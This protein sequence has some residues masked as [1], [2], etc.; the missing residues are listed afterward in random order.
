MI[1]DVKS[2]QWVRAAF[3]RTAA[4]RPV[5]VRR[6]PT[7]H[8]AEA[9]RDGQHGT[10]GALRRQ[11]NLC[12]KSRAPAIIPENLPVALLTPLAWVAGMS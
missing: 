2:Q 3:L 10:A 6:L 11:E 1:R 9:G 4:L 5:D 12:Y 8:N 7:G